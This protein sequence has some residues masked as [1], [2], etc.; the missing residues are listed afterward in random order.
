MKINL[1]KAIKT[2][3]PNP[4]FEQVYYEAIANSI[5]A[6][7]TDI[8][9]SISIN[10]YDSPD[11]LRIIIED[12]GKGFTDLNFERFSSLLEVE[13]DDHKGLGRLIYLHYFNE[14][15]FET[16]FDGN[17][18]RKFI[19]SPAFTGDFQVEPFDS[20]SGT[21]SEFYAFSGDKI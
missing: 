18:R 19:F 15:R 17:K 2:F 11:S 4:S 14:I 1:Q 5:D 6:D 8:K 9:I 10:S 20:Q 3:H 12:N 7:A 13:G 16:H 21:V